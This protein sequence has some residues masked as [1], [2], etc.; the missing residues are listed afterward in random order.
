MNE[1]Q[2]RFDAVLEELLDEHPASHLLTVPGIYEVVSEYYNNEVLARLDYDEDEPECGDCRGWAHFNIGESTEGIQRCD[3]C[4]QFEDDEA[5][6]RAHDLHC[7]CGA[8]VDRPA[9]RCHGCGSPAPFSAYWSF[10]SLIES[11]DRLY[12]ASCAKAQIAQG[13]DDATS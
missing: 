2:Q 9:Q 13:D 1:K 5:A 7:K 12:C 3:T 6:A 8:G 4:E 11:N 10:N